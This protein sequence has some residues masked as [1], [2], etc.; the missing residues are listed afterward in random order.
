M[1]TIVSVAAVEVARSARFLNVAL[2]V[3]LMAVPFVAFTG[4]ELWEEKIRYPIP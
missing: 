2:G 1:L 4:I 3:A